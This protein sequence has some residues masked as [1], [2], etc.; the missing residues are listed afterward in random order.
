LAV[1]ATSEGGFVDE[2]DAGG[3]KGVS[4]IDSANI[5]Y[6]KSLKKNRGRSRILFQATR[7]SNHTFEG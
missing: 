4:E 2:V 1:I 5:N 3:G 7:T 6:I